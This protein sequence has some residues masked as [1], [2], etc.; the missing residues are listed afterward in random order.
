VPV[1]KQSGNVHKLTIAARSSAPNHHAYSLLLTAIWARAILPLSSACRSQRFDH[2]E[3]EFAAELPEVWC[4][5][6][7]AGEANILDRF[8]EHSVEQ[9]VTVLHGMLN[10]LNT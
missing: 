7:Q 4:R 6:M 8:T 10:E 9:V 3:Q 1:P 2:L 5:Y